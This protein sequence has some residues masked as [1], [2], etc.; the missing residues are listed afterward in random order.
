M[1]NK[2]ID[3]LKER[4]NVLVEEI[5]PFNDEEFIKLRKGTFGASDSHALLGLSRFKTKQTLIEEKLTDKPL[6]PLAKS[7]QLLAGKY[8]EDGIMNLIAD[9]Y[10]KCYVHKPV[11][12]YGIKDSLLA[13]NYDGVLFY[14]DKLTAL[15]IKYCS[16]NGAR[17]YDFAKAVSYN[18]INT[19]KRFNFNQKLSLEKHVNYA[20]S[21]YGI[22]PYYY[23]QLQQQIIPLDTDICFL[24]VF[25][26]TNSQTYVFVI[27]KDERVAKEL[28]EQSNNC[29]L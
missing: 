25:N 7:P 6:Q 27:H 28:I 18:N 5:N 15:E 21:H 17:Y 12:M 19:V 13:V 10:F 23:T 9:E 14:D 1:K 20:A 26:S 2:I 11:S 4:L 29:K 16:A 3:E 24:G 8:L 22:P